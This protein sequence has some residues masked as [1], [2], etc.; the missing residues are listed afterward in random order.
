MPHAA[1]GAMVMSADISAARFQQ[2]DRNPLNPN[3]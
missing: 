3:V 1:C 2:L